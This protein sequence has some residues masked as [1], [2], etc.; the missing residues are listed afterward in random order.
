MLNSTKG[1]NVMWGRDGYL[2]TIVI[3]V[4]WVIMAIMI[5]SYL[6]KIFARLGGILC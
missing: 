1:M 6:H 5:G 3:M 4:A 2:G